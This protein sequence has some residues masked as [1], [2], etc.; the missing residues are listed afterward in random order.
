MHRLRQVAQVFDRVEEVQNLHDLVV[1]C[2][3]EG[4]AWPDPGVAVADGN[5][6]HRAAD[7]IAD[8][9]HQGRDAGEEGI[10]PLDASRVLTWPQDQG[11]ATGRRV[12]A[13]ARDRA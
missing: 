5:D 3:H 13:A 6:A 9:V 2:R 4:A 10:R 12:M 11:F 1:R 8:R 7:A